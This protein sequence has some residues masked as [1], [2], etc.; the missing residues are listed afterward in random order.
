MNPGGW[1]QQ[2]ALAL[3]S[4]V[5]KCGVDETMR[6]VRLARLGASTSGMDGGGMRGKT[7]I[8]VGALA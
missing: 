7:V 5:T 8:A 3:A 4:A 2:L 6:A 1:R